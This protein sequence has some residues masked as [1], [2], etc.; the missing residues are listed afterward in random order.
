MV[1]LSPLF[2]EAT[3]IDGDPATGALL[4][5]YVTGSA[6][7]LTAYKDSGSAVQHTNPIV[8]NSRGEPSSP[9]WLTASSVYR[10]VLA[11]STDTDPP[12]SAIRT[13]DNVSGINDTE[14][15][16]IDQWVAS[17]LTPTYVSAT[18]FTLAGDQTTVFHVGRRLKTTNS[19]GTVYSYISVSAYTSLTTVTV[20]NDSG[21][22]DAGLSAVSYGMLSATNPSIPGEL[23]AIL[24]LTSAAD[25]V[26]YFTGANTAALA[27]F[28]TAGRSLVAA[29]TVAAEKE[30]LFPAWTTP[31]FSAGDFTANNSMTWTVAAGDVTT[32]AYIVNGKM[33]TVSFWIVTSTV[34]GTP[35]SLLKIAIPNSKTATKTMGAYCRIYNNSA[36]SAGIAY[37]DGSGTVIN[38]SKMDASNYT[39]ES[40]ATEVSGQITFEIN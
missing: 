9:I 27:D 37:V 1:K 38:I 12:T 23:N 15:A 36:Y 16:T 31:S 22:L 5:T 25:K 32:Y 18:Q 4:F 11:P 2:N 19:G 30:I 21:T 10:F 29:T 24:Q 17:G 40:D 6:T 39:G 14:A 33:M 7:K 35:S 3:F 13:I 26:A 8:L 28:P 20:V 34:G